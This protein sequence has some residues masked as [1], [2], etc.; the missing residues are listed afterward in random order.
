MVKLSKICNSQSKINMFLVKKLKQNLKPKEI[1]R[2]KSKENWG[3]NKK[4][5][6]FIIK[7]WTIGKKIK[8]NVLHRRG[9]AELLNY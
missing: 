1:E 7:K 2:E 4:S 8:M 5:L 3:V 6:M 9:K